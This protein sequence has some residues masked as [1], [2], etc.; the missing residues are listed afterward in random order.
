MLT[1]SI[2]MRHA[3]MRLFLFFGIGFLTACGGGTPRHGTDPS[4]PDS[5][6]QAAVEHEIESLNAMRSRLAQTIDEDPVDQGTFA[7]VCKPVGQRAQVLS[8]TTGW[9]VQQI[10]ET[11]RNPAHQLDEA[12]AAVY[13][14]FADHPDRLRL[15]TRTTLNGTSGW[16]YYRR[17]IVEPSCL[18]CHGAQG[19]RPAFVKQN[20]PQDQAYGFSAG[21]LRGLYAVFV[22][23][24]L[25]FQHSSRAPA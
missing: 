5:A 4:A 6:L 22:P 17:I 10:A 19:D 18:A 8:D 16:R 9:T 24:S 1:G 13:P 20:Y 11:Y 21:D 14:R 23:D 2:L 12:G 7:R 15:W 25:A 3:P